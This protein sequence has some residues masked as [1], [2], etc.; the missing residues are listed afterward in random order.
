M[1]MVLSITFQ[2]LVLQK[3]AAVVVIPALVV[4]IPALVVA[5]VLV[6]LDLAGGKVTN[7]QVVIV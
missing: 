3:A 7:F 5:K 4:A 2:S 6:T 1:A